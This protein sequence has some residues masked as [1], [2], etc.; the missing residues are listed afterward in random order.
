MYSSKSKVIFFSEKLLEESG[1][2][3]FDN[4]GGRESL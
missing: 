2:E 1:G 3:A 4:I